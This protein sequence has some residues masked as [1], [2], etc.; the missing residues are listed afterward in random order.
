MV[1]MV[2]L[3]NFLYKKSCFYVFSVFVLEFLIDEILFVERC[4]FLML[5]EKNKLVE[6]KSV[7]VCNEK[8]K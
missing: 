5:R 1:C 2:F 3:K 6:L 4:S 7:L 8:K